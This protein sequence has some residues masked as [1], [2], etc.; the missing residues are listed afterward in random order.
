IFFADGQVNNVAELFEDGKEFDLFSEAEK[1]L[2]QK[3]VA[4]P[5]KGS[6]HRFK[7]ACWN[8]IAEAYSVVDAAGEM[9]AKLVGLNDAKHPELI[10][11][12]QK[13]KSCPYGGRKFQ[14]NKSSSDEE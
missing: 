5:S 10:Y 13:A 2:I 8:G 4:D 11:E 14:D 1:P 12:R 9:C 7:T 3:K 6:F